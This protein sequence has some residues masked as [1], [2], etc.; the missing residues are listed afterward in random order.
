MVLV[1]IVAVEKA[2]RIVVGF[3][4]TAV[5]R[6]PVGEEAGVDP[7]THQCSDRLGTEAGLVEED[8]PAVAG[9]R[10]VG[11]DCRIGLQTLSGWRRRC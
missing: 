6:S 3:G 5:I 7:G 4:R 10:E 9:R 8:I 1:R 2:N 11:L